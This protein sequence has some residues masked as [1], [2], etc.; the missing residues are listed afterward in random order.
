MSPPPSPPSERPESR[1]IEA[2][3]HPSPLQSVVSDIDDLIG[4]DLVKAEVRRLVITA[5]AKRR[6]RSSG[7][8]SHE[9]ELPT[10]AFIGNPGTGKTTVAKIL[11]KALASAEILAEA[12]VVE[13]SIRD[14]IGEDPD[15]AGRRRHSSC[16][17]SHFPNQPLERTAFSHCIRRTYRIH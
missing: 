13:A 11:A 10:L 3:R 7:I 6:V 14:L 1:A 15:R 2:G 4:R 17:R 5:R 12:H 9:L 16:E 8:K